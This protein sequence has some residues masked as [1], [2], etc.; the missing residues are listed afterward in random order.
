M[1]ARDL[2][3]MPR[4]GLQAQTCGDAH[5]LNF[6]LFA[7]PER[8]LLFD[9]NDF[10]ET[11]MGPWEW[12]LKRLCTSIAVA[13]R[14]FGLCS[15]ICDDCARLCAKAYRENIRAYSKLPLL[16]LWYSRVDGDRLRAEFKH[17][18]RSHIGTRI[19]KAHKRTY[20]DAID[21][22]TLGDEEF[23]K[24]KDEPP[25]TAHSHNWLSR[26][27]LETILRSYRES[28]PDDR[29]QLFDRYTLVDW[30]AKV[31]GV[32]SVG[33]RCF[34]L[35]FASGAKRNDYVVLQMKEATPSVFEGLSGLT[36]PG[37]QGQ[38]T[39]FGQRLIQGF[40]DIFLGWGT[41][42]KR[43]Y[44]IRQLWD[45]KGRAAPD[46][47]GIDE[48]RS[49]AALCGWTLARAHARSG[50]AAQIAGYLGK[51]D[52]FDEAIAR[53]ARAYSDQIEK[54]FDRFK[55]AVRAGD[56]PAETGV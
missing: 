27:E 44:Y 21:D 31:V 2:A 17:N 35:L 39:V 3:T 52:T 16:K 46:E 43:D 11:L 22:L 24:L 15:D 9:I 48:L 18:D 8:N 33:T 54:D 45:M 47:P 4:T 6:G 7:S 30:A 56:L 55:K 19:G 23:L 5:L 14:G 50:N 12:D 53:F 1:M 42:G 28:L 10:D 20:R 25:V 36:W 32:A 51:S 37:N 38:R 26:R 13:S 40:T 34:A 49:Y 41:D 29:R